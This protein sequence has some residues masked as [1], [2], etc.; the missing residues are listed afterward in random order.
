MVPF[1]TGSISATMF[2]S[3]LRTDFSNLD[4]TTRFLDQN[5][6]NP[7]NFIHFLKNVTFSPILDFANQFHEKD[8]RKV[9]EDPYIKHL[10]YTAYL[11]HESSV[12]KKYNKKDKKLFIAASLLH[13]TVEIIRK[14]NPT[15]T[16]DAFY[17]ELT[18]YGFEQN[19]ARK[20]T[21]LTKILTPEPKSKDI[22]DEKWLKKKFIDFK[23]II[24]IQPGNVKEID[25]E[26][27]KEIERDKFQY[28][29]DGE[30]KMLAEMAREIK[31]ADEA[32]NIR[33]TVDDIIQGKDGYKVTSNGIKP[34]ALRF[35]D[36]TNRFSLISSDH[37][38][39]DQLKNDLDFIDNYLK[40]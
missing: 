6:H 40:K 28:L 14:T 26:L 29:N 16:Y 19:E 21:L 36:F 8:T 18:D 13:D 15:F 24:E 27:I 35:K 9:T 7:T 12:F 11:S 17:T 1:E 2:K 10:I 23:T 22:S 32:A 33:E 39:K 37:T 25:G 20:I 34:L 31:L 4:N 38:L 5:C 30:Y 3:L